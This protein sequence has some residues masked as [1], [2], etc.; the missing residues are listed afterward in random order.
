MVINNTNTNGDIWNLQLQ[1]ARN[2]N[3]QAGGNYLVRITMKTSSSGHAQIVLGGWD[4]IGNM[5]NTLEVSQSNDF[6][7]YEVE[8]FNS[9]ISNSNNGIHVL[10]QGRKYNGTATISK[11][12]VIELQK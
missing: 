9:T 11:V 6:Q 4:N 7:S 5:Y 12:E 1:I 2:F 3:I 8:Y 10:W